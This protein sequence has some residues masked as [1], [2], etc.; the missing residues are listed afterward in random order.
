[1]LAIIVTSFVFIALGLDPSAI[2]APALCAVTG[3][4]GL[5][6]L[7]RIFAR[8]EAVETIL[9]NEVQRDLNDGQEYPI[10]YRISPHED[11]KEHEE[12]QDKGNNG[13]T[14]ITINNVQPQET[15]KVEEVKVK[16]ETETTAKK[17]R[18]RPKKKTEETQET[19]IKDDT[20]INN[21]TKI[22]NENNSANWADEDMSG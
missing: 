7:K 17:K 1:M 2:V 11:I 14:N 8:Q 20:Q 21:D 19:Q 5:L 9:L 18:G 3:E 16:A 15:E 4:L 13:V 6:S 22:N 10:D 12:I